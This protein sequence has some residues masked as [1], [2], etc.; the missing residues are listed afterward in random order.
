VK[1]KVNKVTSTKTLIPL[2]YYALPFCVP[3]GGSEMESKNVGSLLAGDHIQSSPY[4]L[5]M[6]KDMYCEQLCISDL[7]RSQLLDSAPNDIV[8]AIQQ[9]YQNNWV[10]DDLPSAGILGGAEQSGIRGVPI[11][12]E[13]NNLA[14][15]YN[16]INIYLMYHPVMNDSNK[17]HVVGF[18]AEPLSI[19]H[20]LDLIKEQES[21]HHF[22]PSVAK[23]R[24]P[25][26]SCV[27]KPAMHMSYALVNAAGRVAQEASGSVLFTYD[28]IW[29][30]SDVAWSN[31]WDTY[32][33]MD[34]TIPSKLRWLA[35]ANSL[36]TVLFFS[37]TIITIVVQNLRRDIGWHN[38]A[39]ILVDLPRPGGWKLI[40]GD[41][42][43]PPL[44]CPILLCVCCGAGAQILLAGLLTIMLGSLGF[45]SP[46]R[47]GHM[48]QGSLLLFVIMGAVNGYTTARLYKTFGGES[49]RPIAFLASLSFP[50]MA[51]TLFM[52]V[53]WIAGGA[54]CTLAIPF[55]VL[56][57][58]LVLWL[59]ASSPLVFAGAF[60]AFKQ[61][62]IQYPVRT[63]SVP[64]RTP[65]QPWFQAAP[66]TMF[67]GGNLPFGC[68]VNELCLVMVN[69]WRGSYYGA[70]GFLLSTVILA[71]IMCAEI[72]VLLTYVQ[73]NHENHRW[74]WRSFA[75]GGAFALYLFGYSILHFQ[76]WIEANTVTAYILYFLYMS[77]ACLALFLAMGTVG[78]ASSLWFNKVLFSYG[79][80]GE[81][82]GETD[83][84]GSE[85]DPQTEAHL[86]S[87]D[88]IIVTIPAWDD[89]TESS[90]AN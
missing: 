17:Y 63:A 30:Q 2:D 28:V 80:E 6:K 50:G 64:R 74:W 70:F 24:N 45:V 39:N 5:R 9:S 61:D 32:L 33:T 87:H 53:N 20:E 56:S 88:P 85:K 73:L 21:I 57:V 1:L 83:Q 13:Y 26:G 34:K 77:L 31:R 12:I 65:E 71:L 62:P 18:R 42:F 19:K 16:H 36:I 84:D 37:G 10:V 78:I 90:S 22:L 55:N 27:T 89:L 23:I 15:I 3:H 66:F 58:M 11:G 51:F 69:A 67:I 49:W 40:N 35:L 7:G 76:R 82:C 72:T 44:S 29:V 46:S 38:G 59:G 54:G 75:N 41:A 81:I 47:R 68:F 4:H 52:L 48:V 8:K 60:L 14:Y 43:R 25:I 86:L 79:H